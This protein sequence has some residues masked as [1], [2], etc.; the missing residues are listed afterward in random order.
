[1][2]KNFATFSSYILCALLCLLQAALAAGMRY[3]IGDP[4]VSTSYVEMDSVYASTPNMGYVPVRVTV[5]NDTTEPLPFQVTATSRQDSYRS[6]NSTASQ[7]SFTAPKEQTSTHVLLV[8]LCNVQADPGSFAYS[9][10]NHSLNL[11]FTGITSGS[12]NVS[13]LAGALEIAGFTK[14]L[15]TDQVAKFNDDRSSAGGS[16]RGGGGGRLEYAIQFEHTYLP[17]DWRAF[18]GFDYLS[19]STNEWLQLT[20]AVRS[21]ILQWVEFGGTLT[22]YT[23]TKE[24]FEQMQIHATP[25]AP[26]TP[27]AQWWQKALAR[28]DYGMGTLRIF[29]WDGGMLR[30]DH[31]KEVY[32]NNPSGKTVPPK[33][34]LADGRSAD[35]WS[36]LTQQFGERNFNAWQIGVILILFGLLVGP[37]NL[38]YL[39][40]AGQRHRL[41]FTTPIISLGASLLLI[42]FILFQDGTGGSG[43]QT[44]LVYINPTA[45]TATIVQSQLSRTGVLFS[46]SF[47]T[48][49]PANV[50]PVI[51]PDSRW[52]RLK[53]NSEGSPQNYTQP[54]SKTYGGDWF[55]S[56]S[57]QAQIVEMVRSTRGRIELASQPGQAPVLRS[58]FGYPI[59]E[60]Y[61]NDA[62]GTLWRGTAALATGGSVTM[63]KESN[64]QLVVTVK[65]YGL[66]GHLNLMAKWA[67][68]P[69]NHF[70]A[71]THDP[72][73]DY[74]SSLSSIDWSQR[75]S[76]IWGP[77]AGVSVAANTEKSPTP[78]P[79]NP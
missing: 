31:L 33:S 58:S 66:T 51:L 17:A 4:K 40:K 69:K 72:K 52:T 25:L 68:L 37:I 53:A 62:A 64:N 67:K 23:Q 16:S 30:V 43:V 57:E 35:F 3:P 2:N 48:D 14:A 18:S 71:F 59:E 47:N 54:D 61:Y 15:T 36:H 41:F 21:S 28:A 49:E 32:P 34:N 27:D 38:F 50:I 74:I 26:E 65:N 78:A 45:A 77:L 24:T 46:S 22:L 1:M 19:F 7:H 75:Q 6:S 29:R 44:S 56:R 12:L 9:Y 5:R 13:S 73:A 39:A 76:L 8:P 10:G 63:E 20:A 70:F 60:I 55:Q 11:E 79:T 42:I